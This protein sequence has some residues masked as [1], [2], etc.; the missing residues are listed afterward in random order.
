[1]RR[2][3]SILGA[4]GSLAILM[5][6]APIQAADLPDVREVAGETLTVLYDG[7]DALLMDFRFPPGVS[8]PDHATGPRVVIVMT[9]GIIER[10]GASEVGQRTELVAGSVLWL[11]GTVGSGFVNA[12]AG[13]LRYLV[14]QPLDGFANEQRCRPEFL[15]RGEGEVSHLIESPQASVWRADIGGEAWIQLGDGTRRSVVVLGDGR[16]PVLIAGEVLNIEN[17][18]ALVFCHL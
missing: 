18:S 9:D 5:G 14:Y 7:P 6:S 4:L 17:T 16:V 10:T 2:L 12:G 15:L 1:V 13:Q 3:K 8:L 11:E